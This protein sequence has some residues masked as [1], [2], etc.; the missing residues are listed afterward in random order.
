MLRSERHGLVIVQVEPTFDDA[1]D[2]PA[3]IGEQYGEADQYEGGHYTDGSPQQTEPEGAY[4]PAKMALQP[5]AGDIIFFNIVDD[6]A[7]D[8]GDAGEVGKRIQDVDDQ[9]QCLERFQSGV[10]ARN[11]FVVHACSFVQESLRV[12][13][14]LNTSFLPGWWSRRSVTK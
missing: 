12:T 7:D 11:E 10:V 9:R 8:G 3:E 14:R 5:G 2:D 1:I 6:N 13:V 4:L